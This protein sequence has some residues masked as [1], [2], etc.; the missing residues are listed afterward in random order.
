MR[1]DRVPGQGAVRKG[2]GTLVVDRA[3]FIPSAAGDFGLIETERSAG[4]YGENRIVQRA[5][6]GNRVAISFDHDGARDRGQ[7]GSDSD[8]LPCRSMVFVPT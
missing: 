4:L 7:L 2:Q 8:R 6:A 5:A 3:A 1:A